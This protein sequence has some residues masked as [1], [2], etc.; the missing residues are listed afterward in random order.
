[1][2]SILTSPHDY[3]CWTKAFLCSQFLWNLS[4]DWKFWVFLWL[5]SANGSFELHLADLHLP[6]DQFELAHSIERDTQIN[7]QI[8]TEYVRRYFLHKCVGRGTLTNKSEEFRCHLVP[9][10]S[11]VVGGGTLFSRQ[12][13]WHFNQIEFISGNF[14]CHRIF[15]RTEWQILHTHRVYSIFLS[16]LLFNRCEPVSHNIESVLVYIGF[17]TRQLAIF[18]LCIQL[19]RVLWCR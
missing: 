5:F 6:L 9:V 18:S 17:G 16:C 2:K 10:V 15:A 8:K 1:M 19:N 11:F 14:R 13:I 7:K 4:L 3:I 12:S